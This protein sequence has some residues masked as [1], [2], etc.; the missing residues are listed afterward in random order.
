MTPRPPLLRLHDEEIIIDSFAGGGGASL[1]IEWATGR[2]PDVAINHDWKAVLMHAANHP[3]TEHVLGSIWDQKPRE[4]CRGRRVALAWWSPDCTHHSNARGGKPRDKGIRGL[5]DVAIEWAKQVRPRVNVIENV[6][7]FADWGPLDETGRPIL[8][9]KGAEFRRWWREWEQLGYAIEMRRLRACDYGAPTSRERLFII[10]R[11]DGEPIVWPEPTHGPGRA[12]SWRTAAEC[13]DF[14]IPC[15]SIFERKKPLVVATERRIARGVFRYTI[16]CADPFIIPLTHGRD[17]RIYGLDE[18]MRTI[19]GANRGEQ[20]LVAPSLIQA[21]YGERDGQAPRVLDIQAP[22]GTVTAGGRKHALVAAFLAKNFGGPAALKKQSPGIPVTGP[23][24][25]I[26][27]KEHHALIASSLVKFK[28]TCLDGQPVTEPLGTV[29]AQ[30]Q[31]YA[32]VR[33]F[34]LKYYGTDQDPRLRD[35]LGTVTTKD[36]FAVVLVHGVEYVIVDIGMRMLVPRE[37]F[38]AQGFPDTYVIDPVVDASGA[39]LSKTDQVDK[40]GNSVCP[41]IAAALVRANLAERAA[42]EAVA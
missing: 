41:P 2:S 22:L 30:G 3:R 29:Q 24:G 33:A 7:E 35:P 20:A 10:T 40:C 42:R 19:T 26:T 6:R 31:H 17:A 21:G 36:R 39:R 4:V 37:L 16:D 13:I 8:D 27:A 11:C 5:A 34:L 32:E 28:G 1:G 38:R 25:A 23:M 15:P 14:G 18:P 9:L 12:Q